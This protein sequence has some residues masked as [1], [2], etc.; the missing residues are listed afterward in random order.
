MRISDWSSDVCSSDLDQAVPFTAFLALS[1][2]TKG[3]RS[4]LL[5]DI[6]LLHLRHSPC[7]IRTYAEPSTESG[8]RANVRRSVCFSPLLQIVPVGRACVLSRKNGKVSQ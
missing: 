7:F 4:T 1:L 2:P 5:A 8:N 3:H 6:F